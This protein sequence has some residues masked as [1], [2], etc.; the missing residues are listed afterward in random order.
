MRLEKSRYMGPFSFDSLRML[1][2]MTRERLASG[3]EEHGEGHSQEEELG[4]HSYSFT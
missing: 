2:H 3:G 4:P 1:A